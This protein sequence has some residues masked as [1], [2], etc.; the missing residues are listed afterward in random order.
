MAGDTSNKRTETQRESDRVE[1]ARRY[2]RG[3]TQ[4]AIGVAL[5]MTQQMVS[6]DLSIIEKRWQAAAIHDITEAKARELAKIDHLEVTYWEAWERSL[7]P[8]KSS[9]V[10]ARGGVKDAKPQ[11]AEQMTKTEERNGSATYLVGVQWCVDRRCKLLGLDA[12]VKMDH[13]ISRERAEAMA[14]DEFYAL[15]KE[16]GLD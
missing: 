1:I 11:T 6:Y 13:T 5:G 3:E 2:L 15:L 8:F 9:T 16:R 10:K 14:D 7:E 4:S 12:P